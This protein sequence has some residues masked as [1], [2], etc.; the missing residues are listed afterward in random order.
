MLGVGGTG[1]LAQRPDD[2][3]GFALGHFGMSDVL[4]EEIHP[5]LRDESVW[6]AFYDFSI[7]PWFRMTADLQWVTPATEGASRGWFAG[8]QTYIKF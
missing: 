6:D 4:K 2:R 3:F 5:L 1:V 8:L 7:A